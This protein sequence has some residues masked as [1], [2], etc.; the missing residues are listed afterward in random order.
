MSFTPRTTVE[1]GRSAGAEMITFFTGPRMCFCGV[2][3]LGEQAGGLHHD[4]RADRSPVDFGG[5]FHLEHFEALAVHGDGIVGVRHLVGQV[6]EDGIVFQQ[7]R[8]GLRVGDV[9][10]RDD[11]DRRIAQRGAHDIPSDAAKSVDSYF[12]WHASS[13]MDLKAVVVR[14]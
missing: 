3:A 1:S 2:G 13:E 9:V 11:F 7:I 4:L 8:E 10:D 14:E 6:A 5:I 12:D